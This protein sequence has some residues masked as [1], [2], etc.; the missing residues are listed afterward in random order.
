MNVSEQITKGLD[1]IKK[2]RNVN[3]EYQL[4]LLTN[5]NVT[6][7]C[8]GNKI[9]RG[10]NTGEPCITVAVKKKE[11]VSKL[12]RIPK[13]ING[14]KTDIVV[15]D[16]AKAMWHNPREK[17]TPPTGGI[18]IGPYGSLSAGTVGCYVLKDGCNTRCGLT[19]AHVLPYCSG[20]D[21]STQPWG[22]CQTHNIVLQPSIIDDPNASVI[23]ILDSYVG[24]GATSYQKV[25]AAIFVCPTLDSD[26]NDI[27]GASPLH[28]TPNYALIGDLVVKSGR[29]TNVTHGYITGLD[30]AVNVAYTKCDGTSITQTFINQIKTDPIV[31]PGDSGSVLI[32]YKGTAP[33]I[34]LC[35]AGSETASFANEFGDVQAALSIHF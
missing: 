27:P 11:D 21:S 32:D 19:N 9:I 31:E 1:R 20:V 18:S 14:V 10:I 4:D 24:I 28:Y 30:A 3:K 16:T 5:E 15:E 34:G 17:F 13:M 35:F 6:S 26:V 7:V 8:V 23:G 2:A 22:R 12:D 29:T 25:D 33:V